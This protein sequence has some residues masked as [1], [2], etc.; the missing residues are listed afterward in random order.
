M[1]E[2]ELSRVCEG[3]PTITMKVTPPLFIMELPVGCGAHGPSISVPP[4]YQ[5]EE[6][7]EEKDSFLAL[8]GTN[9]ST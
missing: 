1:E 5:K 2:L 3:K 8:V 9:G 7:F 6:K 4:Y